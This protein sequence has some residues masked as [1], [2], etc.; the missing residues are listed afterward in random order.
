LRSKR[1]RSGSSSLTTD[2]ESPMRV[3][4]VDDDT[5]FADLLAELLGR[6]GFIPRVA[7][8]GE[9][10]IRAFAQFRPQAALIDISLPTMSGCDLARRL[11]GLGTEAKLIALSGYARREDEDAS[12]AAGFDHHLVKPVR[13]DI[14]E[15]NLRGVALRREPP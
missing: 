7:R 14:I 10:A 5:D 9:E 1:A 3:L 8:D 11:R 15:A 12:L 2:T 4:I 6:R 13:V